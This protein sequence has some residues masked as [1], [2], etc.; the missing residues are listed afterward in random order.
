MQKKI[1]ALAVAG[2]A[3]TAAFAQTNVTIYGV[4]DMAYA[5]SFGG[6]EGAQHNIQ[7]G[8]LSGSRIGFRG[9]EDL[10]NGLKALFVLEYGI[11]IDENDG[12]GNGA[13]GARQQMVGLTGGFGTAVAGRLQ[14]AGYDY[15]CG[16]GAVAGSALD[17]YI[18]LGVGSLLTCGSAGR[19]ESAVAYISPNFGG[20]S[21]AYNHARVTE[22]A[23]SS[24]NN[25]VYA[26]LVAGNYVNGPVNVNFT[27]ARTD[28]KDTLA[29]AGQKRMEYGVRGSF[30]FGPATAF[31]AYQTNR[32]DGFDRDNKWSLGVI[33]PAGAKGAFTAQYAAN[34]IENANDADS[35]AL[36]VAYMH[37][38][39]KRTTIYT[40]VTYVRNDDNAARAA[41]FETAVGAADNNTG[42]FAL[43]LRHTF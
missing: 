25:D 3:S 36:T 17:P 20:F 30:N 16:I 33:V 5:Y 39:S 1:I 29:L 43:G 35:D 23:A 34:D 38:L 27:V 28:D 10:G 7:S 24:Q 22:Q 21:F 4:A 9:T 31:A 40:G 37:S 19:A 14:T 13:A 42:V 26:N 11:D 2:L 8:G 41:G 12:L 18:K 15:A 6:N 32:T